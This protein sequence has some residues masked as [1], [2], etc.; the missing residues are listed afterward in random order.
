MIVTV[1]ANPSMDRTIELSGELLRGQVLRA[2]RVTDQPGGKGVNVAGAVRD[3]GLETM[4]V[5]PARAG[6]PLLAEIAGA[7]LPYCAVPID[8][9]V[10]TNITLAEPDGTTTK[11]NEPGATLTAA[12]SEALIALTL[13]A[14]RG[15]SWVALCGSLPPGLP[16]DWY[17]TMTRLLTEVGVKVAVDT[18][19]KPLAEVARAHPDLLKPNAAEL[20][21]LTGGDPEAMESMAAAGD[22]SAAADAARSLV[23]QTGGSVLTTLGG[24]GALLTTPH[25]TW[26]AVAPRITVRSTVGAGDS[27]LAGYLIADHE[28]AVESLRLASAV[29]YGSAAAS[30]PG[31]TPPKPSDVDR[32]AVHV[33]RID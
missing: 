11:V 3:A 7:G 16:N 2:A 6:D 33:E 22:P 24:A 18:S 32:S 20:A 14:A 17:A 25:G 4:A 27:S 29:A 31:T 23:E 8:G 28:G 30:L 26:Q 12:D 19:G 13:D 15:A 21:E 5:L 10:R 1:T 9:A